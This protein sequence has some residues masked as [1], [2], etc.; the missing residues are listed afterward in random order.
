V[1]GRRDAAYRSG[2]GKGTDYKNAVEAQTA[3]GWP[4]HGPRSGSAQERRWGMG[5]RVQT[6][7]FDN[8]RHCAKPEKPLLEKYLTDSIHVKC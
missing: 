6:S 7:A 3:A 4:G 2:T 8:V 5:K 1:G